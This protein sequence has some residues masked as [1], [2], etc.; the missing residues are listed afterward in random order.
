M[1]PQK[2]PQQTFD[3]NMRQLAYRH[4]IEHVWDDLLE[5]LMTCY[6]AQTRE[7]DYFKAI[8][9]YGKPEMEIMAQIFSS[10][11]QMY[12]RDVTPEGGW[13]DHL[14]DYYQEHI[15]GPSKAQALGQFFT[16][17]HICDLM[18][19][20]SISDEP[21]DN[22]TKW[23][24]DPCCG[25]GRNLLSASRIHPHYNQY[26]NFVGVDVDYMSVRMCCVNMFLH[27]LRGYVVWGNSLTAES[28]QAFRIVN[29]TD[30][31]NPFKGLVPGIFKLDRISGRKIIA[32]G[33]GYGDRVEDIEGIR[34]EVGEG[35]PESIF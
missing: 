18:A 2:S 26:W 21:T 35:E 20:V 6:S 17:H 28:Y 33:L 34:F 27:G 19:R 16:P 14:G 24:S 12:D 10:L 25:S 32:M 9:R 23:V 11:V 5:I 7:G 3:S 22:E 13:A 31:L 1:K 15:L 29:P 30:C 8:K 4:S